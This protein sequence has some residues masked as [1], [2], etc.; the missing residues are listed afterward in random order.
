MNRYEHARAV[1]ENLGQKVA[2]PKPPPLETKLVPCRNC[3]AQVILAHA[4]GGHWC[5]LDRNPGGD[6]AIVLGTARTYG[7]HLGQIDR[8]SFHRCERTQ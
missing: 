5:V 3:K 1:L 6:L 8:F 4:P 2:R 7:P